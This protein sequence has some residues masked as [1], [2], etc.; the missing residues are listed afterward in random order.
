[1][2]GMIGLDPATR[3]LVTGGPYAEAKQVRVNCLVLLR[4]ASAAV[5]LLPQCAALAVDICLDFVA[6]VR[7][8]A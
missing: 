2:S 3:V 8:P 1:M 5:F 7:G 4:V 6:A